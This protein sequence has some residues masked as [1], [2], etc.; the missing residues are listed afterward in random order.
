MKY[1]TNKSIPVFKKGVRVIYR[2]IPH[3]VATVKGMAGQRVNL[4]Y[5]HEKGYL[6][7]PVSDCLPA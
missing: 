6:T 3:Q 5:P 4:K 1:P 2:G 7:V